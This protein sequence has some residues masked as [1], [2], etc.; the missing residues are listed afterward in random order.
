M[1]QSLGANGAPLSDD[2]RG[3]L[4]HAAIDTLSIRDGLGYEAARE[5]LL[6]AIDVGDA[7]YVQDGDMVEVHV[8]GQPVVRIARSTLRDAIV[9]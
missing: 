2:E 6:A 5:E 7:A 9:R 4:A 3:L 1:S 8:H